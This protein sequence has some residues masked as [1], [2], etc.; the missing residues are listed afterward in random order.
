M[1]KFKSM[2]I[3]TLFSLTTTVGLNAE[4]IT[5]TAGGS[6]DHPSSFTLDFGTGLGRSTGHISFMDIELQVDPDN[7]TAHFVRYYQEVEPL[8]L[9]GGLSTGNMVIE[10][11]ANSSNGTFDDRTGTVDTSD[12]Y[13]IYFDGDLSAFGLQ[14]PVILPSTS[15]GTVVASAVNG[16]SITLDW[17][18]FGQ[19]ANPFDPNNPLTF[20]Y[21]C[22]SN[23]EFESD[24]YTTVRI[25]L[26][27]AV[28]SLAIPVV[29]KNRLE[30]DLST[31]LDY[32]SRGYDSLSV[33]W[34]Q[35]FANDVDTM[36][37]NPI[38]ANV[39]NPLI[40]EAE[41]LID[42]LGYYR[43]KERAQ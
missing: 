33:Y 30:R 4:S 26:L 14:S 20:E 2:A 5:V 36:T 23:A 41:A 21:T 38:S 32:L 39:A 17:A 3:V 37:P 24:A 10:I 22:S 34:L 40:N 15:L 6:V 1:G 29:N 25:G 35:K 28:S 19:L 43:G 12:E 42:S 8:T 9:P 7:G 18:G 11:V 13:A 16:G 27:P 31:A